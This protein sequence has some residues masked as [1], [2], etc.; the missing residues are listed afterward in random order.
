M[1]KNRNTFIF[2]FIFFIT[3]AM[4]A[5]LCLNGK[6]SVF[7]RDINA[8]G[9]KKAVMNEAVIGTAPVASEE[10]SKEPVEEIKKAYL[11]PE[12]EPVD[13]TEDYDEEERFYTFKVNTKYTILRLRDAPSLEGTIIDRLERGTPG[14]ILK[15]GDEWCRVYVEQRDKT[16]YVATRYIKLSEVSREEFPEEIREMMKNDG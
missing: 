2:L 9:A 3:V 4:G 10:S 8:S 1:R 12:P 5:M 7:D 15:F 14:H 11:D 13:D 16:G 6:N